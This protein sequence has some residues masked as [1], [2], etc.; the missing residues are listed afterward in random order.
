MFSVAESCVHWHSR[1]SGLCIYYSW[2]RTHTHT[3]AEQSRLSPPRLGNPR[4]FWHY[5]PAHFRWAAGGQTHGLGFPEPE[6]QMPVLPDTPV[7]V[8]CLLSVWVWVGV[9][10]RFDMNI[11]H[12]KPIDGRCYN[13]RL[14]QGFHPSHF[15]KLDALIKLSIIYINTVL[16]RYRDC[17]Y[18]DLFVPGAI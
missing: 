15:V 11:K 4:S 17:L 6:T 12:T 3:H 14:Y 9:G 16:A 5:R 7:C 8:V 2:W 13:Y 10:H 1:T 18:A